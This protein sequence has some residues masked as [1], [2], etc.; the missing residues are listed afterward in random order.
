MS[1]EFNPVHKQSTAV[2]L[3]DPTFAQASLRSSMQV[4]TDTVARRSL[5]L[6]K[7][8]ASHLAF[9]PRRLDHVL[10][11][12]TGSYP[13]GYAK[14]SLDGPKNGDSLIGIEVFAPTQKVTGGNKLLLQLTPANGSRPDQCLE[15]MLCSE[16]MCTLRTH[17]Q[18]RLEPIGKRPCVIF[19]HGWGVNASGYRPLLEEMASHGYTVLSINHPSSSEDGLNMSPEE[20]AKMQAHNIRFVVEQIRNKTLAGIRDIVNPERIVLAGHSMG[21]NA[22]VLVARDDSHIAGCINLDGALTGDKRTEGVEMPLLMIFS[23]VFKD[24]DKM[25]T[26]AQEE[27]QVW[28]TNDYVPMLKTWQSFHENSLASLKRRGLGLEE[29]SRTGQIK[30]VGH[31]DFSMMPLLSWLVGEKTLNSALKAQK[32]ASEEMLKFMHSVL[33]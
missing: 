17:S 32:I 5:D 22:S 29:T 30:G 10:L 26:K 21:G 4:L 24:V 13:V 16:Q 20:L 2:V 11:P 33:K 8:E 31:M 28:K 25:S 1:A 7:F 15:K 14:L 27:F 12:L 6:A 3:Y 19:S 18:D 9:R 23:D